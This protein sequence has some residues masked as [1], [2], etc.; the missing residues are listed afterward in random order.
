MA[1]QPIENAPEPAARQL[2]ARQLAQDIPALQAQ[3]LE[4]KGQLDRARLQK[5]TSDV[6]Q[7]ITDP[8]F[9]EKMRQARAAADKGAGV[10]VAANLLSIEGLREAG[11][12]IPTDFRL[13]SRVFED[14]EQGVRFVID[15]PRGLP[16]VAPVAWGGCA[17]AGGLSFCGC[18]GFST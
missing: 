17:G 5:V 11:V 14:Y 4:A 15:S 10:D 2:A 9:V 13:T 18:G 6:I 8:A 16:G 7:T 3:M 12:D 1:K